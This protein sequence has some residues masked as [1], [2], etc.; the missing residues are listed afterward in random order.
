[1]HCCNL[2]VHTNRYHPFHAWW[3]LWLQG[4]KRRR[5][6]PSRPLPFHHHHHHHHPHQ[7]PCL[8]IPPAFL[9][10]PMPGGSCG[11]RVGNAGVNLPPAPSPCCSTAAVLALNRGLVPCNSTLL[12]DAA[13]A[14]STSSAAADCSWPLI[15][16]SACEAWMHSTRKRQQDSLSTNTLQGGCSHDWLVTQGV[17][18]S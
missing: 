9:S 12:A 18:H 17:K 11:Y 8:Y 5:Q 4:G 13:R 16:V 10:P 15:R 1:M 3:Q 6:P 2:L 7:H 14:S